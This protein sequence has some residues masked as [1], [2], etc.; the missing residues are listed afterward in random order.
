MD[1]SIS[2]LGNVSANG[3]QGVSPTHPTTYQ[4]TAKGPGGTAEQS[5]TVNVN[6]QPT[7]TLALSQP[8][9][10]YLTRSAGDKVVEQDSTTLDELVGV[11]R[12]SSHDPAARQRR[13]QWKQQHS[14]H[15]GSNRERP[16]RSGRDLYAER[17]ERL[18]RHGHSNRDAARGRLHRPRAACHAC[19]PLLPPRPIRNAG[20]Q[21]WA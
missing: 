1:T 21:K 12:E 18:R 16:H 11:Q 10:R 13:Y 8:Q 17:G 20:I 4:L 14:S 5:G 2:N 15:A 6:A 3:E 9:I 7:A 19:E